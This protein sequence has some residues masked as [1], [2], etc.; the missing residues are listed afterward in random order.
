[1]LLPTWLACAERGPW[2][3]RVA[4]EDGGARLTLDA[5]CEASGSLWGLAAPFIAD[6]MERTDAPQAANVKALIEGE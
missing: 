1:M 6:A 2:P 5:A 4:A 3:Y